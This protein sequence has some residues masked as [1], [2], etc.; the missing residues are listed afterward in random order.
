MDS[1]A[2]DTY[3]ATHDAS[4]IS[5]S[6]PALPNC[7]IGLPDGAVLHPSHIGTLPSV[8]HLPAEARTAQIVPG[9][10]QSLLSIP[11]LCDQGCTATLTRTA[12][13]VTYDDEVVYT[14]TRDPD[15]PDPLKRLWST[16][17]NGTK[18]TANLLIH[19]D[20][21]AEFVAFCHAALGSPAIPTF[22]AAVSKFP[23][24]FAGL[25]ADIIRRNIP[26]PLATPRGHLNRSR[27]NIRSTKPST[28]NRFSPL[29]EVDTDADPD[30]SI[31]CD[32]SADTHI[33]DSASHTPSNMLF[34][35]VRSVSEMTRQGHS[36]A[37]GKFPYKSVQGSQ[38]LLC[39]FNEDSNYIHVEPMP[40]RLSS[41]FVAAYRKAM[42][43]FWRVGFKPHIERMDNEVS[44]EVMTLLRKTFDVSVSL[45]PPHNHRTLLAERSIQTF[46]NH[47]I[48]TLATCDPNMPL[49]LW[50]H[51]LP[52][53]ETTLN[54][55][56]KSNLNPNITAYQELF[57]PYDNNRHPL[58]PLGMHVLI[59]EQAKTQRSTWAAHG[60]PGYYL[61]PSLVHYRTYRVWATATRSTRVSDTLSFHPKALHMPGSHPLETVESALRDLITALQ[62]PS[63]MALA[64]TDAM[65]LPN[66]TANLRALQALYS[67]APLSD[68]PITALSS[69]LPPMIP[70]PTVV[71]P[72]VTP[73]HVPELQR[74]GDLQHVNHP[75]PVQLVPNQPL[76]AQLV[77]QPP[78]AVPLVAQSTRSRRVRNK[79]PRYTDVCCALV[80]RQPLIVDDGYE[81]LEAFEPQ[82][83]AQLAPPPPIVIP[84]LQYRQLMK[85]GDAAV[86]EEQN[87][88][89][90]DRL[91]VTTGCIRFCLHSDKPKT[92]K[93]KYCKLVCTVKKATDGTLT[94]RVR[95][96]VADTNSEYSGPVSA[97]TASLPTF[98]ILLNSIVSDNA[99][100][101]TADIKD[102]YLGTPMEHKEYMLIPLRIIPQRI[103]TAYGLDSLPKD[104]S[105]MVEIS[106]G[107]YGL[108]QAGR[109][110]QDRLFALLE[111]NG[112]VQAQHTPCLFKHSVNKTAF[113]LVVDDFGIKYSS[114]SDADHLLSVLRQLY[115]ITVDPTGSNYIGLTVDYVRTEPRHIILSMPGTALEG[116]ARYQFKP[117][118]RRTH[119][120]MVQ[121]PPK[122]G[123]H[124]NERPEDDTSPALSP[125][126]VKR[127]Q[128]IIGTFQHFSRALDVTMVCPISKLA[129][130]PH[131]EKTERM[132]DHFLNYVYTW[133][134][135]RIIF[136]A[137]DMLLQI[138]SDASYNSETRARSRLAG[139]HFLGHY[140]PSVHTKPNGFIST[141]STISDNVCGSAQEAEGMA[142]F[143]NAQTAIPEKEA[144][145]F[146]GHPQQDTLII[147]DNLIG[148]NI[149]NGKLPPKR[150]KCMD[151]RFYWIKDR[152]RQREFRLQWLPGSVNLADYLSKVHP[153]THY[154][155]MRSTYVSDPPVVP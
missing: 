75:H 35:T 131:T 135:P 84:P 72:V 20:T 124:S 8:G 80:R 69:S 32:E 117:T 45:A 89:E 38:Y 39:F 29:A 119:H 5:D 24:V 81:A 106:K 17:I 47:F 65:L 118:G 127:L 41:S 46:K 88:C 21:Q 96:T 86:W 23:T 60:T 141:V 115:T 145:I 44:Q 137:S 48:S 148:V 31:D 28:S 87:A 30:D 155:T 66:L 97:Y 103:K 133:P 2:S 105:V 111:R 125:M 27:A 79:P 1:A 36:D 142:I 61:G 43:F 83:V 95:L 151:M 42:N 98:N 71:L 58:M 113:V 134:E 91:L 114:Q 34:L 3:I 139:Y 136:Y 107:M 68:S 99:N 26:N 104:E 14:G 22:I 121:P 54:L 128:S 123:K 110:A 13:I 76:P 78:A 15:S 92:Q 19:N 140:D 49:E 59:Y 152:I 129:T 40:S 82:P 16:V 120:P 70:L 150:S 149:L 144:L 94:Y 74:V 73:A 10:Q 93:A 9:L 25:T 153:P 57:G 63:V 143:V 6:R 130:A 7:D 100:F 51:L 18:G 11:V 55:L 64:Q 108:A 33:A 77:P 112:Y 90:F 147:S 62:L 122:F 50:E 116:L 102:Y 4:V 52:Q 138:H 67:R 146:L 53:T 56:R 109:L 101:M 85:G 37:T 154:K 126:R 12:A 132:A